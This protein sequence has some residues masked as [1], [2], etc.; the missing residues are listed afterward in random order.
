[1]QHPTKHQ[2]YGHQPSISEQEM[3]DTAGE[4]RKNLEVTFSNEPL[5]TD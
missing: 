2:L 1:M 3:R 5:Y 4:I